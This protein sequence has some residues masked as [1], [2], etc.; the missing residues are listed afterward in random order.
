MASSGQTIRLTGVGNRVVAH[1]WI[2]IAPLGA[3][4]NVRGPTRTNAQNDKMQAMLS[5]IARAKPGGRTLKTEH[6]KC[7]FMDAVAR[8]TGNAAFTALWE[9]GLDGEGVVNLGHRSSR[10]TKPEMSDLID[11]MQAWGDENQI[12]WSELANDEA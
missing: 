9:P 12:Q 1:R 8:E 5:D 6:W 7:L 2:D 3:V 4:V 10:L 11:F